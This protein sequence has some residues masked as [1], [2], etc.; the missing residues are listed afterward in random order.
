MWLSRLLR[1]AT[2]PAWQ[3]IERFDPSWKD[4]ISMMAR[5]IEAT[6][7]PVLDIGCGPMWLR[8][9]LPTGVRYIGLDYVSRGPDCITCD[10]NHQRLPDTEAATYFISGS[11]EYLQNVELFVADVSARARKCI[12]SYCALTEFPSIPE[13]RRRGW[14]NDMTTEELTTLFEGRGMVRKSVEYTP[15]RNA[16]MVFEGTAMAG[17]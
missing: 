12:V 6:D 7:G 16:V 3:D 1:I 5:H 17:R 4:R 15:S 9:F 8:Q 14:K 11:M 2:P 10:L 13:R